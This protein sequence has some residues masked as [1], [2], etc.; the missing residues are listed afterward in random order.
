LTLDPGWKKI[1]SG[2][3]IPDPQHC[4]ED[5]LCRLCLGRTLIQP[6][7]NPENA[8]YSFGSPKKFRLLASSD[9]DPGCLSRILIFTHPG[10]RIPKQQQKRGVQKNVCHTFLCS[11]KFLKIE[12]DFIFEV[13]KKK[14]W[15]NIQKEL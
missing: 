15:P 7:L 2:I 12:N 4:L 8:R 11:H 13:L 9:A 10:S 3:S 6:T 14:I 1:G 5:V